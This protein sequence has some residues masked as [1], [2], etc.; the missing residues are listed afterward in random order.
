[1][2]EH[3]FEWPKYGLWDIEHANTEYIHWSSCEH[4][5][6]AVSLAGVS[7]SCVAMPLTKKYQ[8]KLAKVTK[9][10][11]IVTSALVVFKTSISKALNDSEVNELE[12]AMLQT[13]HL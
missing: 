10:V 12:F 3:L 11:N 2:T 5:P 7:V 9:L 8:K 13:F 4:Y 1:M 6:G